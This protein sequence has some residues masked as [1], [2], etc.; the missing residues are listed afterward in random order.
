LKIR[1]SE[2]GK[3]RIVVNGAGA[4]ALAVTWLLLDAGAVDITICD[5]SGALY[6]GRRSGMNSYKEDI[7]RRTNPD[8]RK[9]SLAEVLVGADVFL[10]LSAAGAVTPDM[11]RAMAADPIV[12]GLANPVPEILPDEAAAPVLSSWPRPQR[13]PNR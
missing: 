5:R 7:A 8:R 1:G 13:L 12:F 9:G 3:V 6:R 2:L 10:G 4:A 11:V